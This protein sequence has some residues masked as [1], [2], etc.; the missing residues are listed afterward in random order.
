M[1]W[2][3]TVGFRDVERIAGPLVVVMHWADRRGLPEFRLV[4]ER[5][6]GMLTRLARSIGI[7]WV[8]ALLRHVG[9]ERGLCSWLCGGVLGRRAEAL[10]ALA[11][12]VAR[13]L[14]LISIYHEGCG[15]DIE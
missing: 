4:G 10:S 5:P 7:Q 11:G 8:L 15:R 3:R 6:V 13:Y 12:P 14:A 1:L 9:N 2:S